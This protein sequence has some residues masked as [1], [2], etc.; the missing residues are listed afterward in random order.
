MGIIDQRAAFGAQALEGFVNLKDRRRHDPDEL[1]LLFVHEL[2]HRHLAYLEAAS[3]TPGVDLLG[4]QRS[5]W[6]AALDSDGSLLEGY[7]WRDLGGG[8][9]QASGRSQRLSLLDLYALGL[10]A[11]DEVPAIT[12]LLDARALSGAPIPPEAQL[13][14]G[15][16]VTATRVDLDLAAIIEQVGPRDPPFGAAPTETR[17]LFALLTAP[18]E[19]ATDPAVVLEAE[20]I[21]RLRADLEE[22]WRA[23]TLGRGSLCTKIEGC[24][25]P[26]PAIDAG[27]A[28]AGAG[29]APAGCSCSVAT[30]ATRGPRAP[31]A[32]PI[33]LLLLVWRCRPVIRW[34]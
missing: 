17:A 19:P 23:L 6:H 1:S 22:T 20:A 16:V 11:P 15:T 28:D 29:E 30:P 9:F 5:H 34:R 4:R 21:D 3:S 13:A 25:P 10:A 27:A 18:G 32:P 31:P 14:V 26:M 12:F 2:A 7:D 8:R 33:L 24:A